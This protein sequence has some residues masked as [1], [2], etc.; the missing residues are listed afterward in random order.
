MAESFE[1]SLSRADHDKFVAGCNT[2]K[3]SS[4]TPEDQ[5]I[6]YDV[7]CSVGASPEQAD[8]WVNL[9]MEMEE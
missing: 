6:L 3:A 4:K 5:D 9:A 2:F 7:L 8:E 1:D